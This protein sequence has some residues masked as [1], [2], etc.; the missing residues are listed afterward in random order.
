MPE[1]GCFGKTDGLTEKQRAF[2]LLFLYFLNN[3]RYNIK[4]GGR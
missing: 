4:K 3:S 1:A 2:P